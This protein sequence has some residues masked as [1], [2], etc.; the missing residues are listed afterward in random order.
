M[1]VTGLV[2]QMLGNIF[3]YDV[4]N[5]LINLRTMRE[6]DFLYLLTFITQLDPSYQKEIAGSEDKVAHFVLFLCWTSSNRIRAISKTSHRHFIRSR[7]LLKLNKMTWGDLNARHKFPQQGKI[8]LSIC[9]S[10][11]YNWYHWSLMTGGADCRLFGLG[12][13]ESDCG[14]VTPVLPGP[15]PPWLCPAAPPHS[16]SLTYHNTI[17]SIPTS[18]GI[19]Y[20][21]HIGSE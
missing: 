10:C 17:L 13:S 14:R 7:Y 11:W 19:I 18:P 8:I 15:P 16:H 2:E 12:R 3:L 6:D 21:I 9:C 5:S 4:E 1:D 20:T